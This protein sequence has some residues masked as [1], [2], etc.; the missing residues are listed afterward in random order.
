M[1]LSHSDC[2]QHHSLNSKGESSTGGIVFII[3]KTKKPKTKPKQTKK[4]KGLLISVRVYKIPIY[5]KDS[6]IRCNGI[7]LT[8]NYFIS[9]NKE[10]YKLFTNALNCRGKKQ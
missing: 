3:K 10:Y 9:W 8:E 2:Y 6:G 1:N 5:Q 7:S 4:Q